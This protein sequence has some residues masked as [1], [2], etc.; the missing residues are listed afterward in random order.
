M[1]IGY[2]LQE[3]QAASSFPPYRWL[4][5]SLPHA[6]ADYCG[7]VQ[8]SRGKV[9]INNHNDFIRSVSVSK[10]FCHSCGILVK[11]GV[12]FLSPRELAFHTSLFN[13]EADNVE[14]PYIV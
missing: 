10:V 4:Y 13:Q 1:G 9:A 7:L 8:G 2:G 11:A 14:S 6:A 12:F 3:V 5:C